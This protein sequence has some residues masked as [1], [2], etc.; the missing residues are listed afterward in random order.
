MWKLALT[1]FRGWSSSQCCLLLLSAFS[2][3]YWI[4]EENLY[5]F[6]PGQRVYIIKD[7]VF[8]KLHGPKLAPFPI[9]EVYTNGTVRIQ[10][11]RV[12]ERINIGQ[13]KA[14]F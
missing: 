2:E 11:G 3:N 7:G 6:S 1:L 4:F 5:D 14:H 9:T 12:N 13:L 10:H 8:R